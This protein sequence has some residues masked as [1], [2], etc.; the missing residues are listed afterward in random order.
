MAK[1]SEMPAPVKKP[2]QNN[3]LRPAF[4]DTTTY[5]LS[6][7]T[8]DDAILINDNYNN[9]NNDNNNDEIKP[10]DHD[11]KSYSSDN[12]QLMNESLDETKELKQE[13]TEIDSKMIN[14]FNKKGFKLIN[15]IRSTLQGSLY[16]AKRNKD[17][18]MCAVK[19]TSKDLHNSRTSEQDGVSIIVEENIILE[20][21]ILHH[22]TVANTPISK[23]YIAKF[24]DFFEDET[25]YYLVMEYVNGVTLRDFTNKCH[26]MIQLKQL[27]LSQYKKICKYILWQIASVLYWLHNDIG[28]C[29]LDLNMDNI[30]IENGTF[31]KDD[32]D[33][34]II[35]Q[36]IN[37][38]LIDFGLSEVF[39]DNQF[40][41]G[42]HG[43]TNNQTYVA[44]KVFNDDIYDG[45]AADIWS[46]GII[47][48]TMSVGIEPYKFPNDKT[49]AGYKSLK[50]SNIGQFQ[51]YLEMTNKSM[52]VNNSMISLLLGVLDFNDSNRFNIKQ[53][54][55]SDYLLSYW[56]K[57]QS[58]I[59]EKSQLQKMQN[60]LLRDKMKD[61]PYYKMNRN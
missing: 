29:H 8:P 22:L 59:T 30:M 24:I 47:L 16:K 21:I 1:P 41:C 17:G 27:K 35:N 53:V 5:D 56:Q 36:D 42:K 31:I 10:C 7:I 34:I 57:Y 54:L 37:I 39:N 11:W 45:R 14:I 19:A 2:D 9:I 18:L 23:D 12:Q 15:K 3:L 61:F 52:F 26:K 32:N 43:M 46:L 25:N 6:P 58:R 60:Y 51:S 44:P 4:I 20:S 33:S 48:F 40:L 49:D 28:C 38:V 13:Y 55:E 50:N